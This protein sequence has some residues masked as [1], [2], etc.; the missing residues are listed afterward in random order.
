MSMKFG[1]LIDVE[2]S[3]TKP[4]VV[5]SRRGC[6]LE[7]QKEVIPSL[8]VARFGRNLGTSFRIARKLLRYVGRLFFQ[9]GSSYISAVD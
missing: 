7:K 9:S 3:N 2:S 4:E 5:W 6:H 1:L 8:R